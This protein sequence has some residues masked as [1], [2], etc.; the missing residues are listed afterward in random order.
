VRA[1]RRAAAAV[2]LLAVPVLGAGLGACGGER[3][4]DAPTLVEELNEAGAGLELGEPLSSGEGAPDVQAI[5][6][7]EDGGEHDDDHD[8]ENA[9]DEESEGDH[10][11]EHGGGSVVILDGPDAA[12]NE[13][14]RC[15]GAVSLTCF[16]A[17]NAVLRFEGLEPEEQARLEHALL[18]IGEAD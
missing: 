8:G 16:R 4:F 11:H 15:Q 13:F 7:E 17:A 6:F 10:G 18:E 5:R 14:A 3:D 9:N 2:A 12:R 1:S